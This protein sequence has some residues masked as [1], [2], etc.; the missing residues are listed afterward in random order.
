MIKKIIISLVLIISI[1]FTL[2][3]VNSGSCNYALW[4]D[5]SAN[6]DWCLNDTQLVSAGWD[7]SIETWFKDKILDWTTNIAW[8]LWLMAVWAIVFWSFMMAISAWEEEKIKKA[9]DMI[10]WAIIWFTWVVLAWSLIAIVV[11]FMYSL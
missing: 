4:G 11:N 9:K 1:F 8:F 10:K 5:I 3:I 2:D 7:I 6:L